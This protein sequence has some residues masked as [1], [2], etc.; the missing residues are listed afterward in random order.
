MPLAANFGVPDR[1]FKKH[2]RLRS[3]NAKDGYVKD[4]LAASL[5]DC[6]FMKIGDLATETGL[7][8]QFCDEEH[9]N[10]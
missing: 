7:F 10:C 6:W 5:N 8:N 4:R 1:L 3:E 9:D 2:G